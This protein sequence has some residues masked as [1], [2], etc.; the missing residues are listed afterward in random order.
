MAVKLSSPAIRTTD[1]MK[2]HS[3]IQEVMN[4]I[5]LILS[6]ILIVWISI[7]TFRLVD[8]LHN[9]NYMT[10]QFWVCVVFIIDF[11]V[12]LWLSPNRWRFARRHILFLIFYIPY[13]NIIDVT[14]ITLNHDAL[15]FIRFLPLARG[16][17]AMS[18][19]VG[20]LSNNA[21]TSL[22]FSYLVILVSVVYFCSLILF[23]REYGIN[24]DVK[25]YWT[26]LWWSCMD[27]TTVGCNINP[28]T[29]A[30]KIVSIILPICGMIVFPLF[31]VYLTDY[32]SRSRG[33]TSGSPDT[34][35]S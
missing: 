31:T 11:F 34:P 19:V 21:V 8:L 20:Y 29:P 3:R 30:G 26:A 6:L 27:L 1:T 10:F 15:Y 9:H 22:F 13:L 14:G 5:V 23:Q 25:D 32:V 18:N 4:M 17:L 24:P 16:A 2:H 7:D 12:E 35:Q 33:N 28:M